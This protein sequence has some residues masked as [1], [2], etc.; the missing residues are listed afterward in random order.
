MYEDGLRYASRI[1][2]P[3]Q[4][5]IVH[6]TRDEQVTIDGS[7]TYAAAY[8]EKVQLVEVDSDHRLHDQLET[9]CG[10]VKTFLL[11]ERR[12]G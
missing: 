11:A 12:I 1:A 9:I 6:G 8:P 5:M 7:R 4:A 2:P 10:Y 3:A